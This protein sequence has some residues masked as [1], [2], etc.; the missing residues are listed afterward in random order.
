MQMLHS[1]DLAF[2]ALR[3]RIA[4]ALRFGILRVPAPLPTS[5]TTSCFGDSV[6]PSRLGESTHTPLFWHFCNLSRGPR[7]R[8]PCYQGGWM[9]VAVHKACIALG[10]F[11]AH[12]GSQSLHSPGSLSRPGKLR[13]NCGGQRGGAATGCGG[14]ASAERVGRRQPLRLGRRAKPS[15][16]LT[17]GWAALKGVRGLGPSAQTAEAAADRRAPHRLCRRP[18]QAPHPRSASV[19]GSLCVWGGGP[20][21]VAPSLEAG[22]LSRG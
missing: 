14:A 6:E 13:R 10:L 8:R 15:G 7:P 3:A 4:V 9:K 12:V 21:R 5:I 2:P 20:N 17:G 18:A 22:L 1:R 19:G 16:P 11:L